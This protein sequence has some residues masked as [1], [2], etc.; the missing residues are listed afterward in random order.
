M[1]VT[2]LPIQRRDYGV[3]PVLAQPEGLLHAP[4]GKLAQMNTDRT[5]FMTSASHS[6]DDSS[7]DDDDEYELFEESAATGDDYAKQ[8]DKKK[9]Q[10]RKWSETVIPAMLKSYLSLLRET[11]SF[12]NLDKVRNSQICTGCPQGRLLQVSCI[13]FNSAFTN[14]LFNLFSVAYMYQKLR[15]YLSVHASKQHWYCLAWACSHVLLRSQP[16]QLT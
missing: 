4:S 7:G 3:P 6:H 12:Q 11:D 10:W 13:Y 5:A 1:H 15:K 16:W 2:N 9:R 14:I 8:Q